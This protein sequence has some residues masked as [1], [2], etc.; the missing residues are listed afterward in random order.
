MNTTGILFGVFTFL[1]IGLGFVWVIKLEYYVG[2][3]VAWAV[4]ALGI[5]LVLASLFV[6]GFT[7]SAVLGV[8]G[9]TLFWGATELAEQ[10]KRVAR[11]LFPTNPRRQAGTPEERPD[12]GKTE[13][14]EQ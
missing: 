3:H 13:G 12:A 10:E 4:A 7:P 1:A 8:L 14:E 6:P 2:A 5:A 11:G 9:G